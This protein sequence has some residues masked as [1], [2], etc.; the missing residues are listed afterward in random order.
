MNATRLVRPEILDSL[1][2]DE[3]AAQ[4]SRRDLQVINRLLGSERWFRR[5][6]AE[7]VRPGG[8][9][10]EIGA[11]DGILG[12]RLMKAGLGTVAGLDLVGRPRFWPEWAPWFQT[13]VFHFD[14]WSD[15]PVVIGNLVFHHFRDEEL[16]RLGGQLNLHARLI[17]ANEP[18]RTPRAARL[19]SALCPLIRADSVTRHDGKV[20][21]AAG[22]R[23]DELAVL[24]GL[25]AKIWT[26]RVEK[27]VLGAACRLIA[28]RRS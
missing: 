8:R 17:V 7:R 1:P 25:D 14:A 27:T 3:P 15:H 21:I 13:S 5:T 22:F 23:D 16:A 19:F 6:L 24:L 28:E 2:D 11:G 9:L 26:W 12:R 10:L 20:S 4:R 18:L